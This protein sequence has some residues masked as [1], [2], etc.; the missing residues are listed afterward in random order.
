MK[1]QTML[2]PLALALLAQQAL[3]GDKG[4]DKPRR[5]EGI[6][7]PDD[8]TDLVTK[9]LQT[10]ARASQEMFRLTSPQQ[11][12]QA[13]SRIFVEVLQTW[14]DTG[15]RMME[16]SLRATRGMKSAVEEAS[17]EVRKPTSAGR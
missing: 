2:V 14:M 1:G 9:N 3:A 12:V 13:Q 11:V 5:L 6:L 15:S 16:I 17:T 10:G 4:P 8:P 7:K